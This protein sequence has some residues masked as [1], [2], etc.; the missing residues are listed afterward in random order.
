MHRKSMKRAIVL[1]AAFSFGLFA[2]SA[3]VA[4]SH[5]HGAGGHGNHGGREGGFRHGGFPRFYYPYSI[6]GAPFYADPFYPY[7]PYYPYPAPSPPP[8]VVQRYYVE[9]APAPP[10]Y[11]YEERSHAQAAP[12]QPLASRME[13]ITLSARELFGFDEARLQAPQ[14]RLDE[15]ADAMVRNPEIERVT[16]TGYTDRIGSDSYNQKLSEHRALAVKAYLVSKG[17]D[18][19]RLEAIG[20][21]KANPIVQCSDK[22][23]GELIKCLEPNRRVEVEQI[24]IE[25]RLR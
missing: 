23:I 12:P 4:Q 25:R 22:K 10:Q 20:N 11:R 2:S 19:G 14:P 21:G 5:G 9:D 6:Y 18:G 1:V 8:L 15:I 7:Y 13:R 17:V 16:I 3:V 24:T